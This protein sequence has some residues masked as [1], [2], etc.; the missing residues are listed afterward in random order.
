MVAC[1]CTLHDPKYTIKPFTLN[2][3]S[4]CIGH[5]FSDVFEIKNNSK[6]SNVFHISGKVV[7]IEEKIK[8]NP[9]E[10][11]KFRVKY[12]TTKIGTFDA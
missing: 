12:S 2:N 1:N 3:P 8:I 9:D 10:T 11:R 5:E 4:L 6:F 7:E